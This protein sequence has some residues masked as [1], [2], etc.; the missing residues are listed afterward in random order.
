MTLCRKCLLDE[1]AG[2]EDVYAHV[3]KTRALLS[4]SELISDVKYKERL[5]ICRQCDYLLDATC[6]KCG[7]YVE[8]RA[9]RNTS[10]CPYKKW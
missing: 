7:C 1:I 2:K 5:D 10:H 6:Q 3:Q 8:I 4:K 9:L